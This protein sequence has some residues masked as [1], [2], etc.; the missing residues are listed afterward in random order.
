MTKVKICGLTNLEDAMAAIQYGADALGFVFATSPRQIAP[1]KAREII[2][3]IPPFVTTVGVFVDAPMKIV[4]ETALLCHLHALQFHGNESPE[5]CH[6][7]YRKVIKAFRVKDKSIVQMT[8]SYEVQAYLLDSESGGGSGRGFDWDLIREVRG[9]I[10]LAGGLTPENVCEAIKR[11]R[12]YAVDVS[13]GVESSP[14]KKDHRRLKEFIE[15]VRQCD[16]SD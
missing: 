15:N 14:G 12:P 16:R 6:A 2:Q 10:I 11:V 4:R 3:R 8:S 7:F 5:Y 1:E 9:R 13:S